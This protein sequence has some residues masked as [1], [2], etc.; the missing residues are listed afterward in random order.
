MKQNEQ[1]LIE[2]TQGLVLVHFHISMTLALPTCISILV[3]NEA[4]SFAGYL[5]IVTSAPRTFE[6]FN[7]IGCG[8]LFSL[9]CVS[10]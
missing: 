9:V 7:I 1:C 5:R 2:G 8:L 10:L 4:H 6:F 3:D